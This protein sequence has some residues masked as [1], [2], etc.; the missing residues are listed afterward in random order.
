[1][2]T[3]AR[4]FA[5]LS[6]LDAKVGIGEL[7]LAKFFQKLPQSGP[8]FVAMSDANVFEST[9]MAAVSKLEAVRRAIGDSTKI[10][11]KRTTTLALR[12]KSRHKRD[13]QASVYFAKTPSFPRC[14]QRQSAAV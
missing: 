3:A 13:F 5:T 1:M 4:N 9:A 7:N 2:V 8:F 14:W 10:R 11:R 6:H 12:D